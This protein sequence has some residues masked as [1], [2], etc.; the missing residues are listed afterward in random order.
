MRRRFA[1]IWSEYV[2]AGDVISEHARMGTATADSSASEFLAP[3]TIL[4]EGAGISFFV[5]KGKRPR[6]TYGK[7]SAHR[8]ARWRVP[9]PR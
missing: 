8:E 9:E 6:G 1:V 7:H 3:R 5:G 4:G 2:A